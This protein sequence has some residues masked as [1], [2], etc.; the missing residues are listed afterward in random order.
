MYASFWGFEK[1]QAIPPN[2]VLTGPCMKPAV[3]YMK[4]LEEKD[5]SLFDWMKDS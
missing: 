2:I 3:D 1:A 5:K 4:V